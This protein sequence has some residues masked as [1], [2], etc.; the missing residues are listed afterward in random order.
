MRDPRSAPDAESMSATADREQVAPRLAAAGRH[1]LPDVA[2]GSMDASNS[3]VGA[4]AAALT[5][6]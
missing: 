1:S 3:P 4:V 5:G 6:N 2:Y